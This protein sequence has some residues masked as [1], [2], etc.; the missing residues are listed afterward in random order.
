M[1]IGQRIRAS[2]DEHEM[3]S[4]G[5]SGLEPTIVPLVNYPELE[6]ALSS[7]R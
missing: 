2:D 7:A 3:S 1:G 5:K 4:D 6:R